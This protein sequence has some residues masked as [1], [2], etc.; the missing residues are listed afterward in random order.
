MASREMGLP[1]YSLVGLVAFTTFGIAMSESQD[2]AATGSTAQHAEPTDA[3]VFVVITMLIGVFTLHLLSVTKI[4]YTALLMVSP[5]RAACQSNLGHD[6]ILAVL[7]WVGHNL[8]RQSMQV[9]GVILGVGNQSFSQSW[10]LIGSGVRLWEVSECAP[11]C[12]CSLGP[13][14]LAVN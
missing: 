3:I 12:G 7:I 8:V 9:W 4:P 1:A 6:H 11:L 5:I 2:N 10:K 13:S 14:N